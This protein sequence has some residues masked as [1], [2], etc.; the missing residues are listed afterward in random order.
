M[1]VIALAEV[2]VYFLEI[3]LTIIEALIEAFKHIANH[4]R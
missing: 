1:Q 4:S 3:G 2:I